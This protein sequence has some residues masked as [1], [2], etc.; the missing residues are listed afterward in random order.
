[1]KVTTEVFRPEKERS[2]GRSGRAALGLPVDGRPAGESEAHD[3]GQLVEGLPGRIVDGRAE[4]LVLTP[5][6]HV[7]DL[8]V[9]AR[10]EER[11]HR[12]LQV[13]ELE[14]WRHQVA[15]HVIDPDEGEVSGPGR[16]LGE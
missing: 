5:P 16:G 3:P 13:L 12:R 8:G 4:R 11:D 7:H 10:G 6:G 9:A 2:K 14:P 1:M 15:L